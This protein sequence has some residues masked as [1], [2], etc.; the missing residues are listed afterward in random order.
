MV[1][2][3]KGITNFHVSSDI[4][5]DASMAALAR[6]GGKMW[7]TE[8]KEEDTITIIPDRSYAGFYTAVIDDMKK[9]WCFRS[10]NNGFCTK[11]WVNGSKSRRIWFA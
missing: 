3:D 5:V 1:N 2:S 7:N 9:T 11:C 8:G 10:K 4:I 6:S